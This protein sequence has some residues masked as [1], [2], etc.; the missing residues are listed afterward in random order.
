MC[1][2]LGLGDFSTL[3]FLQHGSASQSILSHLPSYR[4]DC[5]GLSGASLHSLPSTHFF[6]CQDQNLYALTPSW[7]LSLPSLSTDDDPQNSHGRAGSPQH[8]L[9]LLTTPCLVLLLSQGLWFISR[10]TNVLIHSWL[11]FWAWII[12]GGSSVYGVVQTVILC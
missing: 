7:S 10:L 3:I 2:P 1:L 6:C 12:Y 9:T 11:L 4:L 8:I 5:V